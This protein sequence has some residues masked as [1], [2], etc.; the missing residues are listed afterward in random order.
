M[1]DH[2]SW[3]LFPFRFQQRSR[4]L[5]RRVIQRGEKLV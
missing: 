5:F 3:F 2:P 4:V 1:R